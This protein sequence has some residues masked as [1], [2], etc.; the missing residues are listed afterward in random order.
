MK[1][2]DSLIDMVRLTIYTAY[3]KNVP[4]PNSLL[5]ITK[6]E[7]GKTEVLKKFI[8]NKNI[9]YLSDVTAFG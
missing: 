9:A 3:I 4:K 2:L 7:S 6:P 8:E 1:D 5:V